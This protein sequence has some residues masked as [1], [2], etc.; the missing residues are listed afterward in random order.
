MNLHSESID[1]L[2]RSILQLQT[3]EECYRYFEDL[4]TVKEIQDMAQRLDTAILLSEGASY[5][6]IA[7]Q[8]NIS[9]ATICR[10]NKCLSYGEGGYRAAIERLKEEKQNGTDS[11]GNR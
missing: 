11:T 4:C 3:V 10:V 7:E 8:V 6:K 9:S 5:Q 1:R 2:F